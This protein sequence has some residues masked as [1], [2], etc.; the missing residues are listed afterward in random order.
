MRRLQVV[1]ATLT[2][3][4]LFVGAVS[5]MSCEQDQFTTPASTPRAVVVPTQDQPPTTPDPVVVPT[6][7]NPPSP[8]STATPRVEVVPTREPQE[9]P[10]EPHEPGQPTG[11][12]VTSIDIQSVFESAGF[13]FEPATVLG[14]PSLRGYSTLGDFARID[15]VGLEDGL[16]WAYMEIRWSGDG[17]SQTEYVTRFAEIAAPRWKDASTWVRRKYP[18]CSHDR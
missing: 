16:T 15:L 12:G 18:I 2:A 4:A 17:I 9:P 13:I 10:P 14:R 11:L 8:T 5:T 3:F 6:Q 7:E 1:C